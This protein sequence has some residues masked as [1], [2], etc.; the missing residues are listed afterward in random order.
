MGKGSG[1]AMAT[2]VLW[3]AIY[4]TTAIAGVRRVVSSIKC[5]RHGAF[6]IIFS[7]RPRFHDGLKSPVP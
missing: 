5:A 4:V 2:G 3:A 1:P 7:E 6:I